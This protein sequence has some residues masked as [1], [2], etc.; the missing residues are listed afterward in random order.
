VGPSALARGFN[1]PAF[2]EAKLS[3]RS[4]ISSAAPVTSHVRASTA[5]GASGQ[6]TVRSSQ[7]AEL[8]HRGLVRCRGSPEIIARK[9]PHRHR[10]KTRLLHR[11]VRKV[12]PQ[13][14][15]NRSAA[16]AC[17]QGRPVSSLRY[18]SSMNAH[19]SCHGTTRSISSRN[20]PRRVLFAKNSRPAG[21][22][23]AAPF[24]IPLGC[25]SL[26][27]TLFR[28]RFESS[29]IKGSLSIIHVVNLVFNALTDGRVGQTL[30]ARQWWACRDGWKLSC[31]YCRV[32][33]AWLGECHCIEAWIMDLRKRQD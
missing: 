7:A 20:A 8:G 2:P 19:N 9:P 24:Q 5:S 1:S 14:Q 4:A 32:V 12:E 27:Y 25:C 3:R 18:I 23:S 13:L 26:P 21:P 28:N 29:L 33:D 10:L 15:E 6:R 30:C 16:S 17:A 11:G 22:D 31:L